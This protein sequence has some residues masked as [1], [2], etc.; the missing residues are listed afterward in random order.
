MR[1][2]LIIRRIRLTDLLLRLNLI[3][4]AF[5][6]PLIRSKSTRNRSRQII[7]ILLSLFTRTRITTINVHT[8]ST[9]TRIWN[10]RVSYA[11]RLST[12]IQTLRI[13]LSYFCFKARTRNNIMSVIF[14]KGQS[15]SITITRLQRM[16]IR[17][18]I[19]IRFRGLFRLRL[20]VLRNDLKN[21][22]LMIITT[23]L[24]F[25]LNRIT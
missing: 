2:L 22:R 21:R 18:S 8:S 9:Y 17:F 15:R 13:R 16:R 25:R 14:F 24:H 5:H 12:R 11:Y 23:S 19:S 20:V 10:Q 4:K 7:P 6:L 1:Y 3:S